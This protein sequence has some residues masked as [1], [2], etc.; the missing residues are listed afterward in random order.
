MSTFGSTDNLESVCPVFAFVVCLV[1]R[2][3]LQR[4]NHPVSVFLEGAQAEDT[5]LPLLQVKV[6]IFS[7]DSS[8][9]CWT[10]GQNPMSLCRPKPAV[11][12]F[13]TIGT[14]NHLRKSHV[15]TSPRKRLLRLPLM[16]ASTIL[17]IELVVKICRPQN[18]GEFYNI[19]DSVPN[20]AKV[21]VPSSWD[22]MDADRILITQLTSTSTLSESVWLRDSK[23]GSTR[24][25]RRI[26]LDQL[27]IGFTGTFML[28]LFPWKPPSILSSFSTPELGGQHD[29]KRDRRIVRP[30]AA[31]TCSEAARTTQRTVPRRIRNC[32]FRRGK[33][34]FFDC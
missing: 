24:K 14:G 34:L 10:H 11:T 19:Y 3:K 29:L 6:V 27:S 26:P 33:I 16:T 9:S 30:R 7:N 23:L 4:H 22:E 25:R 20:F 5:S 1:L 31:C 15:A 8:L 21:T 12:S 2:P 17:W 13:Q 28:T 32:V 18:V